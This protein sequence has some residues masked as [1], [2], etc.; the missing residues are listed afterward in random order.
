[1]CLMLA[2][3][4]LNAGSPDLQQL[5]RDGHPDKEHWVPWDR[6]IKLL[7]AYHQAISDLPQ[8]GLI[9]LCWTHTAGLSVQPASQLAVPNGGQ[10]PP[11]L[12]RGAS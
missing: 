8:L 6:G 12:I 2:K 10:I 7:T 1:M 3:A 11:G 9:D 4:R 5:A